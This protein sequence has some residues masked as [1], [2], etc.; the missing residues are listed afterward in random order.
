MR[1]GRVPGYW[2]HVTVREP[3]VE[4]LKQSRNLPEGE[5]GTVRFV[6]THCSYVFLTRT[7]VYKVK[8]PKNYGF[9]DYSSVA[10]RKHFCE[11]E[12]RLNRR[13]APAV[14]LGV[15]PVY[16]DARGFS[17]NRRGD[18]VD[19]AVHMQRL[20]D[21]RSALALVRA[22]ALAPSDVDS[23]V[24]VLVEFYRKAA[25]PPAESNLRRNIDENFAQVEPFVGRLL[26]ARL[27]E[28][29]RRLQLDWLDSTASLLDGRPV[30]DG[31]GDLRLEHVYLLPDGPTIIDCIEFTERFRVGDPVLD[32]A[33]L[34][35]DLE[36][37]Q[38]PGLAE[39][40]IG[41]F[42]YERDDYELYT[43]IDGYMSYRAWVR[44]KVA[45]FVAVDP[46][47]PPALVARKTREANE[48]F[49]LAREELTGRRPPPVV[50]AV[51]GLIG[52]G[53]TTLATAIARQYGM[54]AISAD[55]T[56]KSLAGLRHGE[57]GPQEIYSPEFTRQVHD[58]L[59][60]RAA[61]VLASGRSV[62]LDTSFRSRALRA[63]T[64]DLARKQGGRFLFAECKVPEEVARARLR[65]RARGVSDAREG[66]YDEFVRGFEPV[67][68]LPPAEHVEVDMTGDPT[69]LADGLM[70]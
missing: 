19:W 9:L 14:Y 3:I 43:V 1:P 22:G 23:V 50:V 51:G 10:A 2:F 38:E 62:I 46:D 29:C 36:R 8:R 32:V 59:L 37:E 18:I 44:G 54:P 13:T 69:A 35:M 45:S 6:S 63:R 27:M 48:F 49:V 53:K 60:R 7:H 39:Y 40:L 31:H 15:L 12:V 70:L 30:V 33:F 28:E 55:A 11:E 20:P 41:R 61:L 68:E 58:E 47:S 16:R 24:R 65:R 17:L 56:R 5:G 25:L 4:D 26:D 64:R 34:T 67:D 52:S 21:S 42:A 66:L 57:R